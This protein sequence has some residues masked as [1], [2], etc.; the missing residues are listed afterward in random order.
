M[1]SIDQKAEIKHHEAVDIAIESSYAEERNLS[2]HPSPHPHSGREALMKLNPAPI[3]FGAFALC[4]FV[5]GLYNSGLITHLPQVAIGV[6]FGY[7][8]MGQF[9]CGIC[10]L[11]IG[12]MFAATS[13]LTFSG[14]FFTFGIMIAPGSGFLSAAIEAGGEAE[15]GKCIGLVELGY[16]IAAF[17]FLLGALRQPILVRLVLLQVFLAFFFGA[18][19]GLGGIA[20][21]NVAS[22]WVSFTLAL[23]A[24]YVMCA[25]LFT[26]ETTMIKLPFF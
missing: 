13:M 3:G 18:I 12:N 26:P 11:I 14:F 24:W 23:T 20:K 2:Q 1:S 6:A 19:G 8:A 4:S 17:L 5:L 9:I 7:G 10:E 16:A 21:F 15:V 25:L 22:G